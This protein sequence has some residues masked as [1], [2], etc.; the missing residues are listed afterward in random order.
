MN[1]LILATLIPVLLVICCYGCSKSQEN[2][3]KNQNQERQAEPIPV[4]PQHS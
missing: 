3:E 4:D 1:K 2:Q